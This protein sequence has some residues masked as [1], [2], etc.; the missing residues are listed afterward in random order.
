MCVATFFS[1]WG[2]WYLRGSFSI[3][4]EARRLV[5]GGPY[6]WIRHPMY[7][8]EI[9]SAMVVAVFRLSALSLAVFALFTTL[10][11]YRSRVEEHKLTGCFGSAYSETGG[12]A[13]W[14]LPYRG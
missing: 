2:L 13:W 6:R 4:A 14:F 9:A 12:R 8:G 10:Q 7:L 1:V 11:L 5:T 3:T